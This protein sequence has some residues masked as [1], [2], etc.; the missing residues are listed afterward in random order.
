MLA[1][2]RQG[3]LKTDAVHYK[4]AGVTEKQPEGLDLD[5]EFTSSKF[6]LHQMP[7]AAVPTSDGQYSCR[8]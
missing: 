5:K 3:D 1:D 8:C 4:D 6:V 2:L 7:M